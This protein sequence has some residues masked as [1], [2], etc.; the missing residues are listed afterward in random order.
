VEIGKTFIDQLVLAHMKGKKLPAETA[1]AK[2]WISTMAK[3]VADR[4]LSLVGDFAMT[5]KCPIVR[6]WRDIRVFSIFAGT[7]EVM[8]QII[9][10]NLGL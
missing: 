1:M 9:S 4:C 5:E 3:T 2:H 10:K 7:N 8:K 6:L